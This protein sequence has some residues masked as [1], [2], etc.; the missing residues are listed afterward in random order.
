MLGALLAAMVSVPILASGANQ[1]TPP[2]AVAS[3]PLEGTYWRATELAGK[4]TPSL[5]PARDAHL[6]F[7]KGG[8]VSG[9]DGCNRITGA[10]QVT[11]DA[12]T[13]SQMT[14]TQM[15][16]LDSE[17]VEQPF[18]NALMMATRWTI[19]GDRLELRDGKGTPLAAFLARPQTSVTSELEGTSWQLVKFQGGD[20]TTLTP[21]VRAKYTIELASADGGIYEFEAIAA[22]NPRSPSPRGGR[23]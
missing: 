4:A 18:R 6:I 20:G 12:I 1:T 13:F 23:I 19:R 15:A 5:N 17:G 2:N 7:Q 16:C 10:Y 22:S 11:G 14:A 8:R 3:R 9:S 21:D